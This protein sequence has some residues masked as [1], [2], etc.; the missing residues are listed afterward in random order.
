MKYRII[1]CLI[2]LGLFISACGGASTPTER[3]ASTAEASDQTPASDASTSGSTAEVSDNLPPSGTSTPAVLGPGGLQLTT[4]CTVV[5]RK[6]TPGPT[7]ESLFPPVSEDDW[8]LGAKNAEVT[9]LEY[10][11]FQ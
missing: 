9:L 7:E 10:S 1:L 3:P 5:S 6:P 2:I 4:N 11:D 8:V